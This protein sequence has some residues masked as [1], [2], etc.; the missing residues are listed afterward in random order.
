MGL[1]RKAVADASMTFLWA[2]SIAS[3]G[4]VA[5]AIAPSLGLDGPRTVYVIFALVSLHIF[6]FGFLGEVLGG[7]SFNPTASV[8]F[9]YAGVSKDD[10]LTLA[11]AI[12]A[13]MVGA[14]GG[15]LAIQQVMPKQYQHM[16]E[17]PKL[18]VPLQTGV[19]AEAI[20]TFAITLI[21]M[22][23][24]LRGPRNPIAK[25]FCIIFATIALVGAGG[26]YTGPAMNPANA[27]AWAF[28]ANQH[29]SWEHFAVYW[30]GPMIGTIFAVWAFNLLF[31]SQIAHN[32]AAA[33]KTTKASMKE[34]GEAA[35]SKKVKSEDSDDIS[36]KL[37]AS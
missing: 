28:V 3:L 4:A 34:D 20:L 13:Q 21:V 8:A 26:A 36:N 22:W 32:K 35:K 11:V 5:K 6:F 9:A 2:S 10:L 14:V 18:K 7:A 29:A 33:A 19:I 16:L 17:G 15:V 27:F 30:V 25:T 1:A 12:P 31:G 23:A 24:L 37:K